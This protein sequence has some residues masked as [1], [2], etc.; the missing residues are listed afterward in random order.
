MWKSHSSVS[1]S[2]S[3]VWKSHSSV[4]KSHSCEWKSHHSVVKSHSACRN[5]T[6][7]CWN[8]IHACGNH[9]RACENHTLRAEITLVRVKL[10]LERVFWKIE[11]VLAKIYLKIDTH[12]CEF[13]RKRVIF[14]RSRVGFCV[15]WITEGIGLTDY[16]SKKICRAIQIF[17]S[18]FTSPWNI[19]QF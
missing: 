1:K 17:G 15:F 2:H 14:A 16:F 10:T 6:R 19:D 5:N 9:T 4:Y 12:A 13:T 3:C 11:R 18:V 7:A 8:D